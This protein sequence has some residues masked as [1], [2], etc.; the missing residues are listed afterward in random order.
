MKSHLT[1]LIVL[2]TLQTMAVQSQAL[3]PLTRPSNGPVFV[4]IYP[5]ELVMHELRMG[6]EI[7][8]LFR[9]AVVLDGSY[10]WGSNSTENSRDKEGWALK[11]DYRFY[12]N[13][14]HKHSRFFV[15]PN[16][17]MKGQQFRKEEYNRYSPVTFTMVPRMVYCANAKMGV[18]ILLSREGRTRL[19]LFSGAGL[20]YQSIGKDLNF[21]FLALSDTPN[22]TAA[23]TYSYGRIVPNI[24]LGALLKF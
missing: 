7:P 9:Q 13:E 4:R 23:T 14:P 11:M 24:L 10:F 8:T 18:D 3:T 20:R 5:L 2:L 22:N 17:M 15:G 12:L 1:I 16:L 21:N 6:V 19:E